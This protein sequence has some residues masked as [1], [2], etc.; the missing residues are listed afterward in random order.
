METYEAKAVHPDTLE[1]ETVEITRTQYEGHHEYAY[2]Y[3][4]GKIF[5]SL[6]TNT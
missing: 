6:Q 3:P 4:D 1:I 2:K 5:Y